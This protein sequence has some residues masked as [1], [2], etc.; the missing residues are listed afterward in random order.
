[1]EV[2]VGPD[3]SKTPYPDE[4]ETDHALESSML[5]LLAG[6]FCL[7]YE[8]PN[9][10]GVFRLGRQ[11]HVGFELGNCPLALSALQINNAEEPMC[12]FHLI[13]T[14]CNRTVQVLFR[15]TEATQ[16]RKRLS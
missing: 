1:V 7:I 11:F 6:F 14:Q 10:I 3:N 16:I 8:L 12:I 15:V 2:V 5:E 4:A 13:A 9:L